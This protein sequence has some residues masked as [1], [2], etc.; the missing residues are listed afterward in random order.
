MA[1][2]KN[3]KEY[4]EKTGITVDDM[5]FYIIRSSLDLGCKVAHMDED[6]LQD[7]E[8]MFDALYYFNELLDSVE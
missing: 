5:K 1:K 7:A 8:N 2:Y 3:I 4:V 6:E